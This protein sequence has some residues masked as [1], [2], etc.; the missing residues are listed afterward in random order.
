MGN[1]ESLKSNVDKFSSSDYDDT[2]DKSKNAFQN[3]NTVEQPT[4][5]TAETDIKTN[6]TQFN[7]NAPLIPST[8]EKGKQILQIA[9]S[10]HFEQLKSVYGK[11]ENFANVVSF[12]GDTH[13]GKSTIISEL[14]NR[15]SS[16][17]KKP[18]IANHSLAPT[19]GDSNIYVATSP[20]TSSTTQDSLKKGQLFIVDYEGSNGSA[21]LPVDVAENLKNGSVGDLALDTAL[22]RRSANEHF[23]RLALLTSDVIVMM[24]ELDL[25]NSKNLSQISEVILHQAMNGIDFY[26][27]PFLVIVKNKSSNEKTLHFE[28]LTKEFKEAHGEQVS[29][30]SKF[31]AGLFVV[32]IPTWY[33]PNGQELFQQ[34]IDELYSLLK[35]LVNTRHLLKSQSGS[36]ISQKSWFILL[37]II[38]EDSNSDV[39]IN[40]PK[41]LS[42]VLKISAD[43]VLQ[44]T[45]NCYSAYASALVKAE[46]FE[47]LRQVATTFLLL[48][49]LRE[50]INCGVDATVLF[51]TERKQ[52]FKNDV[53]TLLEQ[54]FA[55]SLTFEPCSSKKGNAICKEVRCTHGNNHFVNS[56]YNS[57][58]VIKQSLKNIFSQNGEQETW[59]GQFT[60][61][62][63]VTEK[64]YI[65]SA[66]STLSDWFDEAKQ[67][68]N[69]VIAQKMYETVKDVS[70]FE[71]IVQASNKLCVLCFKNTAEAFSICK[72][73]LFCNECKTLLSVA[74]DLGQCE[75]KCLLHHL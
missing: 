9:P 11:S 52:K 73:L 5:V 62:S 20:T 70:N 12:I 6:L 22:R 74:E 61:S 39:S 27:K 1:I 55:Y 34:K 43:K 63:K 24:T 21:K 38:L 35:Q 30:L 13:S 36:L 48:T 45:F 26:E 23:P 56:N 2:T 32:E 66:I 72:H 59:P 14:L 54:L 50:Y 19:T 31:Y 53:S 3:Q 46:Q 40:F 16:C 51:S 71:P 37:K 58:T 68:G 25:A 10:E 4:S 67:Q 44:D 17:S 75:F 33:M 7:Y 47:R 29:T 8:L 41:L 65:S 60:P 69:V 49:S 15:L 42:Q 57:W 18:N 64:E 28:V